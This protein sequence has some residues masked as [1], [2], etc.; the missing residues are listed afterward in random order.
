MF[1][2]ATSSLDS[3]TEEEISQTI[4]DVGIAALRH[5][6]AVFQRSA[7]RR[8]RLKQSDRLLWILLSRYWHGWRRCV[9]VVRPDTVVRWHRR[10]F[11]RY[12]TRKSR[13]CPGRPAVAAA[14]RDLIQRM[15]R[16]NVLWGAP[17][18]HGELLKLG[19]D[20]A[21]STVG[22]YLRRNRR[23]PSQT[24]R[25]FLKNPMQQMASMDFFTVPTALFRVLFVFVVL[26]HDRRRVVHFNVTEHP[27]AEWTAQQIREAFPWD[28]APRYLIRDRDAI[29]GKEVIAVARAWG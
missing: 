24:W 3:L 18:I 4:R 2:E 13:R 22:K 5:Q 12:W 23:P 7:P 25:P 16:A 6:I 26:S 20:V 21:P 11:A 29:F 1:D 19:I 28:E 9:Y 17:R 15:S 27:T 14:I 10:A 8:L